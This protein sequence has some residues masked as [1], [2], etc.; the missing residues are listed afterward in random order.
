ML[1]NRDNLTTSQL[2]IPSHNLAMLTPVNNHCAPY[3]VIFESFLYSNVFVHYEHWFTNIQKHNYLSILSHQATLPIAA[4]TFSK[5]P[6]YYCNC[7][8]IIVIASIL[9]ELPFHA[10]LNGLY[11]NSVKYP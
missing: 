7:Q 5:K 1:N 6:V 2:L 10:E 8:Y 4:F 9:L 3:H 11:P